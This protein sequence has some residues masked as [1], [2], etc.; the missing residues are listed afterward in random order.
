MFSYT[1]WYLRNMFILKFFEPI[2]LSLSKCKI[3]VRQVVD[4]HLSRS[5]EFAHLLKK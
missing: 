5:K 1:I 3:P 4:R 2:A